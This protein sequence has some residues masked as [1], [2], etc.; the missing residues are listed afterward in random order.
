VVIGTNIPKAKVFRFE[1]CWMQHSSFQDTVQNAWNILVRF[2]NSAKRINAKFKNMRRT[3]KLWANS[4]LKLLISNVKASIEL[5]D[6]LEEFR[7]LTTEEA[8]LRSIL[9]IHLITLLK[10]QRIYW[11]QRG[12]VKWVK[13]GDENTRFFHTKATISYRHNH[14]AT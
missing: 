4:C 7:R 5:L 2:T 9:T 6:T 12:K 8:H 11:R 1:N 13:F 10:N 14:I 3:L